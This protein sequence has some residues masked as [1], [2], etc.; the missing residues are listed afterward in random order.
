MEDYPP[1]VVANVMWVT[2]WPDSKFED[3]VR[4]STIKE[5]RDLYH[6]WKG[7]NERTYDN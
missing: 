4:P 3:R 1:F 2:R 6:L 5:S 7:W